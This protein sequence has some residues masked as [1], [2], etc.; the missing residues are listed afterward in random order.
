MAARGAAEEMGIPM[1]EFEAAA[2]EMQQEFVDACEGG[3]DPMQAFDSLEPPGI[4]GGM[5]PQGPDGGMAHADM[6]PPG[7]DMGG[8]FDDA[9]PPPL[10]EGDMPPPP[11]MALVPA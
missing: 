1:E 7:G 2:G 5:G 10:Q 9:P 3:L 6:P 11:G 4:E 8:M